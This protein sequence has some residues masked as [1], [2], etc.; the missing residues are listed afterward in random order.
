MDKKAIALVIVV[1]AVVFSVGIFG[2]RFIMPIETSVSTPTPTPIS[3]PMPTPIS[4]A[5]PSPVITP[6]PMPQ[7][8]EERDLI[9]RWY[10]MYDVELDENDVDYIMDEFI[11]WDIHPVEIYRGSLIFHERSYGYFYIPDIDN[12]LRRLPGAYTRFENLVK[13]KSGTIAVISLF[14]DEMYCACFP[15]LSNAENFLAEFWSIS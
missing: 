12:D 3:I 4:R 2:G 13:R 5:T 14:D 15:T 9:K 1:C 11:K 8:N 7:M 6:T 10:K